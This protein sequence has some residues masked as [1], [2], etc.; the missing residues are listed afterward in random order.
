MQRSYMSPEFKYNSIYG[1]MNMIEQTS[2]FGSKMLDIEDVISIYGENIIYYQGLNKE[3]TNLSIE[4]NLAPI[5]YSTFLDKMNNHIIT[6]DESQSQS[7]L[8]TN[9]R[10]T[11]DIDINKI[12]SNYLFATLKRYRTFEGVRNSM[13]IYNNIDSA[14]NEYISKNITN[15]YKYR[16]I[17]FFIEYKSFSEDDTFKYKNKFVEIVDVGST[18]TKIQS[19]INE[20]KGKLIVIFNQEKPSSL[21]NFNYYFNLTF[22]KL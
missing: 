11:I 14:I 7:Q 18:F 22:D 20:N 5:V 19:T 1:T 10:W 3:Q 12:L 9:T 15:R 2:F 17:D 16:S 8:T 13:T 4:K 6:I 21:Y